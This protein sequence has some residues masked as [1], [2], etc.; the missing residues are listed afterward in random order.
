MQYMP[1]TDYPF[2][3]RWLNI[4]HTHNQAKVQRL[5]A[6]NHRAYS[7]LG[8]DGWKNSVQNRKL[9]NAVQMTSN[10]TIY[11]GSMPLGDRK[12]N[13]NT[14]YNILKDFLRQGITDEEVPMR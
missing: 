7:T 3:N 11:R 6:L 14:Q 12:D 1:K 10:W 2:R 4:L 13:A 9:I 5:L 8:T